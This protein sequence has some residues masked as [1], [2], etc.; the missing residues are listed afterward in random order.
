[1]AIEY[2]NL[3]LGES[4]ESIS[5]WSQELSDTIVMSFFYHNKIFPANFLAVTSSKVIK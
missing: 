4:E 1:V 3:L 5:Y 2:L